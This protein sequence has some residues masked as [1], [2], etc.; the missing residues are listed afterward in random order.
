MT[1]L[2]RALNQVPRRAEKQEIEVL[3]ATFVNSGVADVLDVV[4][5][6]VLYGRRGTGKTHALSYL[7]SEV[8]ARGDIALNIDLRTIGSPDGLLASDGAPATERATRL[9]IDLLGQ[10]HN[11]ILEK[12]LGDETLLDDANFVERADAVLS[13]ITTVQI[14]GAVESSTETEAKQLVK[15]ESRLSASLKDGTP[16]LSASAGSGAQAEDRTLRREKRTGTERFALNFTDIARALRELASALTSKRV[17]LL[18]DEWS[19]VPQDLQPYLAEFLL[20]CVLPLQRFTVKIAAIEQ[21][22][23]FMIESDGR[24]VGIEIGADMGANVNLDDFLVYEGSEDQSRAFFKGLFF[25]HLRSLGGESSTLRGLLNREDDIIRKAFTDR[26]AFDELVRAAEGVPRDAL[27]IAGRAA[28]RAGDGLISVPIVREAARW[29]FQTDKSAPLAAE[30]REDAQE[31]LGWIIERVIRGKKAR[32][33]LVNER[34]SRN[35][36]LRT[37]FDARVLHIV[38]RGY[39]AQ[40]DPGQRYEVWVIDYGAYVDLLQTQSA[41]EGA[42]PLETVEGTTEYADVDVPLQDLRA[43]RRAV[44]DLGELGVAET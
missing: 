18:L 37:L 36:L 38:R 8:E 28:M 3:H 25:Q 24:R 43:I 10:L 12:V 21:H 15:D 30:G 23:R 13:A 27:Y 42:L 34:Q 40:D 6:Q 1:P 44:L 31:L 20:R 29:W 41:P 4:D 39:S 19:S 22:A 7:G 14:S 32:A 9:L 2:N 17:W 5:H 26:R 35:P 11:T 16:G 33:F